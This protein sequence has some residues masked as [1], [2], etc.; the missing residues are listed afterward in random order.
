MK[1][2]KTMTTFTTMKTFGT[3]TRSIRTVGAAIV[4]A[5]ALAACSSDDNVIDEQPMKPTEPQVYT[6][7]VQATKTT[8]DDAANSRTTRALALD[9]KTLNATWKTGE[10]VDVYK[11][12]TV[13]S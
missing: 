9:G 13:G 11:V 6:M 5:A 1:T 7:T 3:M 2:V 12:T 8:G 10:T 4:C